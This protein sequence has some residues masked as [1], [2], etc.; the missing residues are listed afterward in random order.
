MQHAANQSDST[1][2]IDSPWVK[3]E[4]CCCS[5]CSCCSICCFSDFPTAPIPP[6]SPAPTPQAT[7]PRGIAD[8]RAL[9]DMLL[10]FGGG[11]WL[12]G[13]VPLEPLL[14]VVL[15]NALLGS[16]H[17]GLQVEGPPSLVHLEQMLVL[18]RNT[19]YTVSIPSGFRQYTVS[20]VSSWC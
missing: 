5:C 15:F 1:L 8:E 12:F 11:C 6:H 13:F 20:P 14:L 3:H 10:L 7:R 4:T 9:W 2:E 17:L 16:I 19:Q 18:L